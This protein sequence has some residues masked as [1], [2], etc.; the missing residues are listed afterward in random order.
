[1]MFSPS[2]DTASGPGVREARDAQSEVNALRFDV[3]RLLLITE[4][5]WRI[6]K[7]KLE[8]SDDDLV[9][10]INDI[11]LEDGKLSKGYAVLT[12]PW[13]PLPDE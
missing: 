6:A 10:R 3:E 1:M 13:E 11:D 9:R 5:L 4:A 7:E 12:P 2:S 8:C